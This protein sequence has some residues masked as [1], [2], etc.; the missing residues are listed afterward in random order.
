QD[1]R[2]VAYFGA[3]QTGADGR[4][5]VR[6]KVPEALGRYRITARAFT[7]S[8]GA[9][10]ARAGITATLPF[11]VRLTGPRVLTQGDVGSAYL[12]VQDR[13]GGK[14]ARA[15]LSVG[16]EVTTRTLTLNGGDAVARFPLEAP[17]RGQQLTLEARATSSGGRTD[18]LR[19]TLPLRPA[20]PRTRLT[21]EG[22]LTAAGTRTVEFGVPSGEQAEALTVTLA[23][24]P[25][26]A[27]LADLDAYLADPA[28]R[29]ATTDAVAARLRAN[30]D[31][32]GLAG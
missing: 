4:A 31:L 8:G 5:Q 9:G 32:V 29:W 15:Q 2:E 28:Q 26:Q 16:T 27:A 13:T 18:A 23:A 6:V 25:L 22:T 14:T 30:L 19:Q 10:D 20:G 24:T 17:A 21:R 1:L 3:V 11:A 7:P 12:G